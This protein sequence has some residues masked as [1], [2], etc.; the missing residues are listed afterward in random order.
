MQT[1]KLSLVVA[2]M[3]LAVSLNGC[4][5]HEARAVLPDEIP[6]AEYTYIYGR[7]SVNDS[8]FLTAAMTFDIRCTDGES[9]DVEFVDHLKSGLQMIRLR[10][11]SCGLRYI[12]LF[13]S[14]GVKFGKGEMEIPMGLK[15]L[16]PLKPGKAYYLGDFSAHAVQQGQLVSWGL[17]GVDNYVFTT[18]EMKSTFTH[19]AAIPTEDHPIGGKSFA[20]RQD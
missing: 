1:T 9:F 19:L 2:A 13:A 15:S 11:S 17:N 16:I 5:A 4:V 14:D 6:A 7:F 10:P 12:E 18:N 20:L 3:G 8:V